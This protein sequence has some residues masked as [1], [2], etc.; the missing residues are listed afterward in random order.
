[1]RKSWI[2]LAAVSVIALMPG[3]ARSQSDVPVFTQ[4]PTPHVANSRIPRHSV[5]SGIRMFVDWQAIDP[6]GGDLIYHVYGDW[7]EDPVHQIGSWTQTSNRVYFIERAPM[8]ELQFTVHACNAAKECTDD[9]TYMFYVDRY[10][11]G[12]AA[13]VG[14]RLVRSGHAWGGSLF[15]TT[16][17]GAFVTYSFTQSIG[18]FG[19][20]GPGY[21]A[22]SVYLDGVL[23]KTVDGQRARGQHRA[24]LFQTA[25]TGD[26]AWEGHVVRI[27][28]A[29]SPGH[30]RL[31]VDGFVTIWPD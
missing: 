20:R 8:W 7:G 13:P 11:Q 16:A 14:W 22:Y 21:G 19:S 31:D 29:A 5:N 27:V 1:M 30:P 4:S 10:Q 15:R 3:I 9:N 28:N 23:V 25:F 12:E 6:L 2:L 17:P 18:V 26:A 24:L